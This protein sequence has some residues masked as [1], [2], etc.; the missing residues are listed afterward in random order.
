MVEG[1]APAV[2]PVNDDARSGSRVKRLLQIERGSGE[3]AVRAVMRDPRQLLVRY[4]KA[5]EKSGLKRE[6]DWRFDPALAQAVAAM[7]R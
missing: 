1:R 6:A 2:R 4:D 7:G 5:A 3:R